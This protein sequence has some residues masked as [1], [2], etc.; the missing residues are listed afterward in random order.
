MKGKFVLS[1]GAT[2]A[3][4]S[5]AMLRGAIGVLGGQR[6]RLP[7]RRRLSQPDRQRH[8]AGAAGHRG[9]VRHPR[10]AA[11]PLGPAGAR[12]EDHDPLASSRACRCRPSRSTSRAR[13]PATAAPRRKSTISGHL[14][15]R[16]DQAGRQRRQ[17][18]VRAHPRDRSRVHQA[19]QRRQAAAPQAHHQL[20]V[21]AGDRRHQRLLP[22]QSRRRRRPIIGT[23]NFDMEG[24]R[25]AQSRSFWVLQRTPDTFPSYL[26][27]IAQSMMEYIADISRERVRFRRSL[28]GYAPTQPVESPRGSKDAFYIKIDKHYGSS[29]HVAY[30]RQ[31]RPGGHVHHL[32]RHVVSLVGGHARQAGSHPVQARRRRGARLAGRALA[33]APTRWRPAS[34]QENLGRGLSRMG[35]SHTKGL[36]YMADATDAAALTDGLQGGA[37]RDPASGRDR[38]GRRAVGQRALDQRGRRR[39]ED[40]RRSQPLIDARAVSLMNEMK[41]AYSAA[42]DAAGRHRRRA[43][44]ERRGEG[45]VAADGRAAGQRWRGARRSAGRWTWR[46]RAACGGG[47][48]GRGAGGAG[49]PAVARRV[50][51]RNSACCCARAA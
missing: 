44:H 7:A 8:R 3:V 40:R 35:E 49:R 21:R 41:A 11:Q 19:D 45:G 17:L 28:T 24:I 14:Y 6:H 16:R 29:D 12:R 31:R 50:H 25:V 51:R 42:G 37:E 30:M 33:S 34:S 36:G 39:E 47:G 1:S 38:E 27:D 43:G 26:N 20:P 15:R 5:L 23:L 46:R 10:S 22:G 18:R 48:G 2:G 4:Y 13:S 32:A 9:L